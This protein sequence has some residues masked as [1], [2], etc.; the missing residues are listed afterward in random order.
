M[1]I[2]TERPALNECITEM[3]RLLATRNG[4]SQTDLANALDVHKAVINR[5]FTQGRDWK[6]SEVDKLAGIF[7]VNR[8][9][10]LSDPDEFVPKLAAARIPENPTITV[11]YAAGRRFAVLESLPTAA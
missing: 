10:L 8:E 5:A 3:V 2:I 11:R 7:G 4:M 6:S 9:V 1:S